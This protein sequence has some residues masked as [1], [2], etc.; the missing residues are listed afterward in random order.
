MPTFFYRN[1][2]G[3]VVTGAWK[4][5]CFICSSCNLSSDCISGVP[6][7]CNSCINIYA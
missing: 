5:K 3:C 1:K 7:I 6:A 2:E 4:S